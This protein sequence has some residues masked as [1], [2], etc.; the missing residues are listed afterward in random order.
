[1]ARLK[2]HEE[3][4]GFRRVVANGKQYLRKRRKTRLAQ[5]SP[6][7]TFCGLKFPTA[8]GP[9]WNGVSQDKLEQH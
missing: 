2:G 7:P 5:A 1:M 4:K 8:T 6:V 9:S 3:G